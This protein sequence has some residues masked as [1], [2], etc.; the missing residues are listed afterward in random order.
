[1]LPARFGGVGAWYED[2]SQ[3][4]DE[5]VVALLRA[6]RAPGAAQ[7]GEGPRPTPTSGFP[8]LGRDDVPHSRP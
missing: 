4:S 2:F 7:P 6:S 8:R 3:T 5:E 1:L